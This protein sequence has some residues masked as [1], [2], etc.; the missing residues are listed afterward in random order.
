MVVTL[1]VEKG[2]VWRVEH[3]AANDVYS[4]VYLGFRSDKPGTRARYEGFA[5]LPE[6]MQCRV[7]VLAMTSHGPGN[8]WV[9][10]VGVRYYDGTYYIVEPYA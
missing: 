8:E 2:N 4:V 9:E 6:W 1:D 7:A 3:D 5:A 10:S